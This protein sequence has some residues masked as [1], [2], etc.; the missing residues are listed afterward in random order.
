MDSI[1]D[2]KT[3]TIIDTACT[4][5]GQR[6]NQL[7][8]LRNLQSVTA[9]ELK[10]N[11]SARAIEHSE[12]VAIC[13]L[14]TRLCIDDKSVFVVERDVVNAIVLPYARQW[15][16]DNLVGGRVVGEYVV[17]TLDQQPAVFSD[18]DHG[19]RQSIA[20]VTTDHRIVVDARTRLQITGFKS[21][22]QLNSELG[23]NATGQSH[24]RNRRVDVNALSVVVDRV[25]RDC[26]RTDE[27]SSVCRSTILE[28]IAPQA[29]WRSHGWIIGTQLAAVVAVRSQNR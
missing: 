1:V 11:I 16:Q 21:V 7:D 5:T 13:R 6:H 26:G 18:S 19:S 27:V 20:P 14:I 10:R 17:D 25:E 9:V 29:A 4:S 22:F 12:T 28:H 2:H 3:I 24:H 15:R 23:I 8:P